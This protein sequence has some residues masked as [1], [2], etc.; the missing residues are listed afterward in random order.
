MAAASDAFLPAKPAVGG[1][2][3]VMD[4]VQKVQDEKAENKQL[5]KRIETIGGMLKEVVASP[6]ADFPEEL[7][8]VVATL[9]SVL[10]K[11]AD[12]LSIELG[13]CF[14][15]RF[16][17]LPMRSGMSR[18]FRQEIVTAVEDYKLRLLACCPTHQSITHVCHASAQ[19]NNDNGRHPLTVL[20]TLDKYTITE[21]NVV[22]SMLRRTLSFYAPFF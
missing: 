18:R 8:G 4:A 21:V 1:L 22:F 6:G 17:L 9:D 19:N 15:S 12:E 13:K 2:L 5:L 7:Q 14:F 10:V 3:L 11:T 16:F 20:L